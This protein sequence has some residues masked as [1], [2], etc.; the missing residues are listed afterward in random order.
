MYLLYFIC[1]FS[2]LFPVDE[3]LYMQKH[4]TEYIPT[5]KEVSKRKKREIK[6]DLSGKSKEKVVDTELDKGPRILTSVFDRFLL[7]IT[8]NEG[9]RPKTAGYICDAG[10]SKSRWK[11]IEKTLDV[12]I[13]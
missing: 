1:L 9:N 2:L 5:A 13:E 4:A 3:Y 7:W 10:S 12:I 8:K 11:R 6:R